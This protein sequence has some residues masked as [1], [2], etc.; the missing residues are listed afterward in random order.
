MTRLARSPRPLWQD[1]LEANRV[2]VRRALGALV[3]R[4]E[5]RKVAPARPRTYDRTGR[6]REGNGR[7]P[8]GKERPCVT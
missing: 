4:L 6:S 3:R 7:P 1:I 2:E 5:R 8:T